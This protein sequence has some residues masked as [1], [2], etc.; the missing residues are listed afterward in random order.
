MVVQ[1]KIQPGG[2]SPQG[3]GDDTAGQLQVRQIGV[4]GG[5]AVQDG[6]DL[7][8]QGALDLQG[9][10]RPG[11]KAHAR[12]EAVVSVPARI[13]IIVL[14]VISMSDRP[15]PAVS[16]AVVAC[17]QEGRQEVAMIGA[18]DAAVGVAR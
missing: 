6:V 8:V 11:I 1:V 10:R 18:V 17:G 2:Y 7:A 13:D 16:G 12:A 3:L 9:A 5:P 14:S 4:S 15:W